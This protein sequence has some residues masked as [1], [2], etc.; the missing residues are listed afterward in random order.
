VNGTLK[1]WSDCKLQS[2]RC[3][4]SKFR[5]PFWFQVNK[6]EITHFK[7]PQQPIAK[8]QKWCKDFAF[9]A[10][11]SITPLAFVV[12]ILVR[13]VGILKVLQPRTGGEIKLSLLLH[14]LP[15]VM[16]I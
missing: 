3:N 5:I 12:K 15:V 8:E 9:P 16:A 4:L 10:A 2:P 11:L 14:S 13:A 1:K 6:S 7:K